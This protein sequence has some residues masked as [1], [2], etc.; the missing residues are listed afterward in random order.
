MALT[1]GSSKNN[2]AGNGAVQSVR[3]GDKD[4]GVQQGGFE[5]AVAQGPAGEG[6]GRRA[7]LGR[8]VQI[9]PMLAPG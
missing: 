7:R 2:R 3:E 9:D 4:Q 8:V 5:F 1:A 6:E